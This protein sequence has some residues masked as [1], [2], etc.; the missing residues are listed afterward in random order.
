MPLKAGCA[1]ETLGSPD[2]RTTYSQTVAVDRACSPA[3]TR[4]PVV[5]GRYQSI[6][7]LSVA[8]L[9]TS[10][11]TFLTTTALLSAASYRRPPCRLV[12]FAPVLPAP[13]V[14]LAKGWVQR[15]KAIR[16]LNKARPLRHTE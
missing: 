16:N 1:L 13:K 4:V 15:P 6:W 14:F 8:S 3:I 11:S 9:P 2:S 5:H 10:H 12:L 7:H